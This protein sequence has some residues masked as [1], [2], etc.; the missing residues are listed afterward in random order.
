MPDCAPDIDRPPLA[1]A[2]FFA[3]ARWKAEARDI[4]MHPDIA[5]FITGHGGGS[6]S[7]KYGPRWVKT[8]EGNREAATFPLA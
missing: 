5:D 3:A 4:E 8:F 1:V 2:G 6:A 7:K